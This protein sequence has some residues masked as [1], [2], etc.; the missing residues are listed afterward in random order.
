MHGQLSPAHAVIRRARDENKRANIGE[1]LRL[2]FFQVKLVDTSPTHWHVNPQTSPLLWLFIRPLHVGLHHSAPHLLLLSLSGASRTK[3]Q[4][5]MT[6]TTAR[7]R[8]R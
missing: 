7:R 1:K 6:T 5:T 3:H 8:M 2:F 4:K